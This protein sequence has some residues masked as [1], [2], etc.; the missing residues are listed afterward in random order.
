MLAFYINSESYL[1]VLGQQMVF[2]LKKWSFLYQILQMTTMQDFCLKA[3]LVFLRSA[4]F[5]LPKLWIPHNAYRN[6]GD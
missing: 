6:T 5:L 2:N 3:V 4:L 1:S